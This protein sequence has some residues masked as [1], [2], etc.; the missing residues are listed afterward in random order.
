MIAAATSTGRC[1][2]RSWTPSIQTTLGAVAEH[3]AR[4]RDRSNLRR[5]LGPRMAGRDEEHRRLHL[6]HQLVAVGVE[7]VMGDLHVV[8]EREARPERAV[9]RAVVLEVAAEDLGCG[10]GIR[11]VAERG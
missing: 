10:L 8:V 11:P 7:E 6:G 5:I 2:G 1:T 3:V 4:V 9:A